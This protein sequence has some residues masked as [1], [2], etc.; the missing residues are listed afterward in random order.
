MLDHGIGNVSSD[1]A[2]QARRMTLIVLAVKAQKLEIYLFK[3]F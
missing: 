2:I 1:L 3:E